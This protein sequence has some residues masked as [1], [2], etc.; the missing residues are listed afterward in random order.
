MAENT[1][2]HP[3]PATQ[4]S[5]PAKRVWFR[6]Y[7]ETLRDPKVR[8]LSDPE[9]RMWIAIQTCASESPVRGLLLTTDGPA[10]ASYL[11]D[12]ANVSTKIASKTLQK[13][14]APSREMIVWNASE[15]CWQ[16][17]KWDSRQ[18]ESDTSTERTRAWKQ[19]QR[20]AAEKAGGNVPGNVPG[21]GAGTFPGTDTEN[22]VQISFYPSSS[23]PRVL[24]AH[25]GE[26][27]ESA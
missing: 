7:H 17:T 26:E 25:G 24:E 21:N 1:T 22:I 13:L 27:E 23:H 20:E 14:A 11:A 2:P 12:L 9:F 18:F 5:A 8:P 19:R 15:N 3:L 4:K 16:V 6:L 10:G